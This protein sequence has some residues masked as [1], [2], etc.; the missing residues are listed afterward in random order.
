MG[1]K[2]ALSF[3]NP[4][5]RQAQPGA[6]QAPNLLTGPLGAP[7]IDSIE[8]RAQQSSPG[9]LIDLFQ[10]DLTRLGG[11]I[12]YFTP[13]VNPDQ[14]S[15]QFGGETYVPV[16]IEVTGFERNA[17]G[18][19]PR[20]R[21]R[22]ANINLAASA[23]VRDYQD[24]VGATVTHIQTFTDYLDTGPTPDPGQHFPLNVYRVHAKLAQNRLAIEFELSASIDQEG[25]KLPGRQVLRIC[26]LRYR[27]F[28]VE[29]GVFEYDQTE[30]ACP[31]TGDN[32]YDRNNNPTAPAQD[33][34]SH[35]I[36]GCKQRFGQFSELPY[37]GFPGVGLSV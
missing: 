13:Q 7:A 26:T 35:T 1:D 29:T 14:S 22:I 17:K 28:N 8:K 24:M 37:G 9:A 23:L 19:F 4:R 30:R 5:R 12:L 6:F 10:I 33:R 11:G 20:P 27:R 25:R 36:P 31:Y 3:Q 2:N 15:V 32:S 18:P 21:V 34:C 16:P